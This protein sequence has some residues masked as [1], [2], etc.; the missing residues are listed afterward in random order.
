V[1][2]LIATGLGIITIVVGLYCSTRIFFGILG[3]LNSPE[4]FQAVY[5]QWVNAVGGKELDIRIDEDP[6]P[7]ANLV[8]ILVLGVGSLVLAW[9]ALAIMLTGAKIVTWT[10]SDRQAIKK[11]LKEAFGSGGPPRYDGTASGT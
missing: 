9:I 5:Q 10:S 8:A 11:I 4:G 1:A 2:R 3:V 6:F 7:V